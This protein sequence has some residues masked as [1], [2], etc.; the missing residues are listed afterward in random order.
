M[1]L[2]ALLTAMRAGAGRAAAVSAQRRFISASAPVLA[3]TN[4]KSKPRERRVPAAK[5]AAPPRRKPIVKR[6]TPAVAAASAVD[7][8]VTTP[9]GSQGQGSSKKVV[10]TKEKAKTAAQLEAL[11]AQARAK[12]S[13]GQFDPDM[14]FLRQAARVLQ[15]C[16]VR[17]QLVAALPL[18]RIVGQ[19]KTHVHGSATMEC[20][21]VYHRLGRNE[22]VVALVDKLLANDFFLTA[23]VLA[24]AIQAAAALGKVDKGFRVYDTAVERG[25][26]PNLGVY[27]ALLGLCGTAG[28][29]VRVK[30]L[31]RQMKEEGIEMNNITY[32]SLMS[33]YSSAGHV[34]KAL[35]LFEEMKREGLHADE[36]TYAILMDAYAVAGDFESAQKL[37]NQLKASSN[38]S[39]NLV[40]YN[41]LLKACGKVSNLA[42]AFQLYEEMK[43]HK[44]QPDLIT[45][46]TMMHAVFHGE[47]GEVDTKKVKAALIGVGAMGVA[48]VP[49]IN[50]QEY[51][52][53]TL[54]CGSL[55]GSM[56]L[57]AYMNPDGVMRALYP[58]SDE[59]K[60]DT[61]I[62]AFFRRLREEDHCGRSMYLWREMLKYNIPADPRVYDVLVRT[63]VKKRHP[64]LGYEAVF[65]EKLPLT[66]ADGKFV[67]PLSTTVQFLHSLL[68]QRR[69]NMADTLFDAAW[70]HGAFAP[71]FPETEGRFVYDLRTFLNVQVRSYTISKV[72]DHLRAKKTAGGDAYKVPDVEFLVQ[73]GYD[74]LDQLDKDDASARA[75]FSMDDMAR[76][77]SGPGQYFFRMS[78]SGERLATFFA[79]TTASTSRDKKL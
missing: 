3:E 60:N 55:V 53:T 37:M 52:L 9:F 45:Y 31:I 79:T 59:P 25:T 17:N 57:A 77:V 23:S 7:D 39:P 24:S 28:D 71:I 15:G 30:L 61:V 58:N 18:C 21:R 6:K 70:K 32:H 42:T 78:V 46:I 64:E 62:E 5:A 26:I 19:S 51:M 33:S 29:T 11:I 54:F 63:C 72:L 20:V 2:P 8:P 44:I 68:A 4:D 49:F 74:L 66:D 13:P 35:E 38:L 40:H 48:F 16:K 75:L 67:L 36:H 47:L 69:L 27:S 65:E 50:Y 22:D 56:G 12:G 34:S 76:E 10:T 43:E 73:H 14:E 1:V 41:V